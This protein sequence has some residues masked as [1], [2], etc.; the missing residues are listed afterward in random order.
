MSG[1][2][3]APE[4]TQVPPPYTPMS[5]LSVMP[6]AF[7]PTSLLIFPIRIKIKVLGLNSFHFTFS[8]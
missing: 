7:T 2:L 6:Q 8:L 3:A 1:K 5:L 4:T